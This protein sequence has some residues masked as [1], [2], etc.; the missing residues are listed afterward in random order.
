MESILNKARAILADYYNVVPDKSMVQDWKEMF[1]PNQ[2]ELAASLD[3]QIVWYDG[4]TTNEDKLM[5][6]QNIANVVALYNDMVSTYTIEYIN[7]D[8]MPDE[9]ELDA[10]SLA[11]LV[12]LIHSLWDELGIWK[13]VNIEIK[14]D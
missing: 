4:C 3:N 5:Y 9:T 7:N 10:E 6:A 8:A 11:D 13:I 2:D 12:N 1:P 14:E